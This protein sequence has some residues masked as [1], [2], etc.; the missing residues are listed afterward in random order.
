MFTYIVIKNFKMFIL[1]LGKITKSEWGI[2]IPFQ[3]FVWFT[4]ILE[5]NRVSIYDKGTKKP[6]LG[7]VN[8]ENITDWLSGVHL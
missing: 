5:E 6:L 2:K 7:L 8:I 1:L 3:L 4:H